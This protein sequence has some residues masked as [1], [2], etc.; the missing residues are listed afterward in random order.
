LKRLMQLASYGR[1]AWRRVR[2]P[3]LLGTRLLLA[4]GQAVLLV[5]QTYAHGWR[6]PGGGVKR[7]ETLEQA[8]R[9]EAAEEVGAH[10]GNLSLLG[11]YTSFQ[12]GCSDHIAVFVCNE[13]RLD[14]VRSPEIEEVRW[15]AMDAL[16]PETTPATR[17]RVDEFRAGLGSAHVGQW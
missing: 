1:S 2:R 3:L 7:G 10:L 14:P 6:L 5:R 13:Y 8:A 11:I 9:R 12:E 16:P 4:N 15:F 17:R